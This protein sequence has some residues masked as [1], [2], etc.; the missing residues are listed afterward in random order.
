[1]QDEILDFWFSRRGSTEHGQTRELW[2]RKDAAVDQS[3]RARFG[4]AVET[5]PADGV[6]TTV[7]NPLRL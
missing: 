2:F 5:A 6:P 1:M 3:I 4:A 7:P